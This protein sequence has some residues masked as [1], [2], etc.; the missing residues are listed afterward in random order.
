[1][2]QFKKIVPS[3]SLLLSFTV[4]GLFIYAGVVKAL[5]PARFAQDVSNFRLLPWTAGTI[6]ALYLPWLEILCG[7]AL[8]FRKLHIGA[9]F[10]LTGLAFAFLVALSLAKIRGV[11]I[12]CG[13]FGH[14]HPH[15]LTASILLDT[16]ILAALVFI[17]TIELKKARQP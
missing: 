12:S 1:M 16:G 6:V 10:I 5:D 11:D 8:I 17:L 2:A 4:G 14:T 15:S 3:V 13:C 9:S 7:A